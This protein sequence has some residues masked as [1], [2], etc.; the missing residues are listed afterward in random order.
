VPLAIFAGCGGGSGGEG[1]AGGGIKTAVQQLREWAGLTQDAENGF[2]DATEF[3]AS[4]PPLTEP[5]LKGVSI[6]GVF[7]GDHA[8]RAT[9][10]MARG[11]NLDPQEAK[12]LSC[13]LLTKAAGDELSLEPAALEKEILEY[14]A[15]RFVEHVPQLQFRASVE[16]FAEAVYDAETGGE[17]AFNAA[18]ATACG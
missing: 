6:S 9:G 16:G 17:A 5:E 2:H 12:N 7:D 11:T 10:E 13:F 15:D 14:I 1:G 3:H 18:L 8:T 4:V